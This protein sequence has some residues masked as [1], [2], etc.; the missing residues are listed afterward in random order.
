VIEKG[1]K[2][3]SRSYDNEVPSVPEP[4]IVTGPAL[5]TAPVIQPSPDTQAEV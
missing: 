1:Y 2:R 4:I 3:I 5:I